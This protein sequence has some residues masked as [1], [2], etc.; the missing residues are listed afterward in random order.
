MERASTGEFGGTYSISSHRHGRG[1]EEDDR[2]KRRPTAR[3]HVDELASPAQVPRATLKLIEEE[4]AQDG[5]A[6]GP[7]ECD[8]TQVE[9]S[10]D[11]DVAAQADEVDQDADQGIQPYSE[12][13]SVRLAPDLVPDPAAGQHLVAGKGPDGARAGLQRSNANKVHNDEGG[14]GEEDGGTLAHDVVV[15]LHDG[16]LDH[17]GQDILGW[18][19]GSEVQRAHAECQYQVK[20]PAH[21]VGEAESGRDG[22]RHRHSRILGLLRDVSRSIVVGHGPGDREEAE[23]EAEAGGRPA[24]IGLDISEDV[25]CR[26]LVLLHDEEGDTAG[27]Q[28]NNVNHRIGP[29]NLGQ[30]CRV[31]TVDEGMHDGQG[32]HDADNVSLRWRIDKIGADGDGSEK[33]LRCSIRGRG[34]AANLADQIQPACGRL[35]SGK[36]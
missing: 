4:L 3:V 13:R 29:R 17:T 18:I 15:D 20:Q 10:R 36:G 23:Q 16:L 28:H 33:H 25:L 30:P 5:D 7:V 14:D 6:V 27:E 34:T 2:D 12:H 9:D 26:V 32:S 24:R 1:E 8:G 35:V 22:S 21:D 19:V 31:Q 11:G